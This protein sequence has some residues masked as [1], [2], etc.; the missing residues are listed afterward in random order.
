[1]KGISVLDRYIAR[2]FLASLLLIILIVT[3]LVVITDVLEMTRRSYG[4]SIN[5]FYIVRLVLLRTPVTLQEILPFIM[6]ISGMVCYVKLSRNS[7]LIVMRSLGISAWQFMFPSL[8]VSFLI[9]A[10][11]VLF[12]TPIT[13]TMFYKSEVMEDKIIKGN[14][15]KAS[16]LSK[17]LWLR[18]YTNEIGNIIIHADHI[19]HDASKLVNVVLLVYDHD[20]S[21]KER[22]DAES[23]IIKENKWILQNINIATIDELKNPLPSLEFKTNINVEK[24]Q[25]SF[26]KPNNLSFWQLPSFIN[27]MKI[28]GFSA[29]RH[30][31]Y[32]YSLC[33][34]PFILIS[35]TL[36]SAGFSLKISR[37]LQNSFELIFG[38]VLS[39]VIYF[40]THMLNAMGLSGTIPLEL[41][42]IA[43]LVLCLSI[44]A[45]I[46]LQREDG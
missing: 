14:L 12:I 5:F 35:M 23:A 17:G 26:T 16:A 37:R 33:I 8:I 7:E 2:Q 18:D 34:L 3:S 6:L 31:Q 25:D 10:A 27:N 40:I 19:S 39:F 22:I 42:V 21:F 28:A 45:F 38:I 1:M 15:A 20:F 46:I 44:A 41:A 11:F 43:P 9:G 29:L 36:L 4:R 30:R 24:L 13:S 32:Y